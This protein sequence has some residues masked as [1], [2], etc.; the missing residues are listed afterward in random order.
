MIATALLLL[1]AAAPPADI[2]LRAH[3]FVREGQV[4]SRGEARLQVRAEPDGGGTVETR[5]QP[6]ARGQTRLRQATI[7]VHAEARIADP[8]QSGEQQETGTSDPR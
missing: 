1:Q 6:E 4:A 3:V 2:E 8:R 5:R 7:D